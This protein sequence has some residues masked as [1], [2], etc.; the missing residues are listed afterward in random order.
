MTQNIFQINISARVLCYKKP[1][2][3][4]SVSFY[5]LTFLAGTL[6]V[7]HHVHF[8][9]CGTLRLFQRVMK[10]DFLSAQPCVNKLSD[11]LC[12]MG[13]SGQ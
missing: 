11:L 12:S 4:I 5:G 13:F 10:P 9:Q 2:E 3:Q 6:F 8:H 7:F 1:L